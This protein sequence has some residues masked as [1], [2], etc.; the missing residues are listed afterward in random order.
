MLHCRSVIIHVTLLHYSQSSAL[1]QI[2]N[3]IYTSIYYYHSFLAC[4]WPLSLCLSAGCCWDFVLHW[5]L[6]VYH[7]WRL[8]PLLW[9]CVHFDSRR[10]NNSC[11]NSSV[12]HRPDWLLCNDTW[13]LLWVGNSEFPQ[14]SLKK[15]K[16]EQILNFLGGYKCFMCILWCSGIMLIDW[17]SLYVSIFNPQ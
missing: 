3:R 10:C 9:G 15:K 1:Q 11:R 14:L 5:S 17:N 6:C 13:E 7:I 8:W 2:L 16:P 12:H 4:P